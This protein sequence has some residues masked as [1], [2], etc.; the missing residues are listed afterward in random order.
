MASVPAFLSHPSSLEHDTGEHPE[1]SLR[2]EAIMRALGARDWLGYERVESPAAERRMLERVHTPA[3]IDRIE[4]ACRAGGAQLDADT[5]VSSGSYTAA[6]HAAGGAVEL[7]RRLLEGGAGQVG[8]SAH[9]PP[10]HHALPDRPMGFCLFNNVAVAARH[11]LDELGLQ[12]VLILDWDVHHGNGTN[13][14]FWDTDQVLFVS[15]HQHPL[16]P[17]SGGSHERGAGSGLDYTIN[18]PVPPGAGD[19]A[20]TSLLRDVVAPRAR[21]Y[22]PQLVL[23]SAGYDAHADDPLAGCLLS[24][25][26]YVA[27]TELVRD[28]AAE[29]EAPL[30]C[31]LEGG[32][33]VDAL[34]RCVTLTME[35]LAAPAGTRTV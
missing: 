13:D 17:G 7:V 21:D 34:A 9:R 27:M 8:F 16:W 19:E 5:V 26:G 12:R 10:G 20:F 22:A 15:I 6:L 23:V 32:Y 4:A 18:L 29:L 35:T 31:L 30:G 14:I 25:A 2:I 3:H 1:R 33:D 11:A 24:D 28:L